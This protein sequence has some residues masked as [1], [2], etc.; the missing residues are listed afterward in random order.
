MLQ[1]NVL[2]LYQTQTRDKLDD[3]NK[4]TTRQ[5]YAKSDAYA[6]FKQSIY[7][8]HEPSDLILVYLTL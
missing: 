2:E 8:G 7:V 5:K 4:R 3:Y 6:T 1:N